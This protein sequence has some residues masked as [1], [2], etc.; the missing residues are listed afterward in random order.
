MAYRVPSRALDCIWKFS[1]SPWTGTWQG[2]GGKSREEVA[3][4]LFCYSGR[5]PEP[6]LGN[7]W[8]LNIFLPFQVL[9]DPL[10]IYQTNGVKHT[11]E[12]VLGL[13]IWGH[14]TSLAGWGFRGPLESRPLNLSSTFLLLNCLRSGH[15]NGAETLILD[16]S[17]SPYT[18]NKDTSHAL[19]KQTKKH[20][21]TTSLAIALNLQW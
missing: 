14:V 15:Q 11:A 20:L 7:M 1:K 3:I 13:C 4:I 16:K 19:I 12:G 8:A 17:H 9:S 10:H 6:Q 2:K 5:Y 18:K 21:S